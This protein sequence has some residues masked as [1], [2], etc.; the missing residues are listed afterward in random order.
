MTKAISLA[1][2]LSQDTLLDLSEGRIDVIWHHKFY[3]SESCQT[4]MPKIVEAC[5]AAN[6][7]LTGDLQSLGTSIGEAS[8]SEVAQSRYLDT[9][10][11]TTTQIR[12]DIFGRLA[13]PA[14]LV[15]LRCD[16]WWP[17]G[18]TLARYE[19]RQMLASIVRRWVKGG[20]ANP[21]IDQKSV[22]L[23]DEYRLERRI[24]VNVYLE[25]PPADGGGE[26]DFW[27]SFTDESQYM[28]IKRQD[29]G[30][31]R[32]NLGEP[33][34]SIHPEQ[35]DLVMFDAARVHG[36]RRLTSGSRITA[37][38]FLGVRSTRDPIVVF[39]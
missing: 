19:G 37:A 16:E 36:V 26:V 9:A 38:C 17:A 2:E 32:E 23:L 4:A 28:S 14:D 7:T 10:Q 24:G 39:A 20:H 13:A 18:V 6:Y 1:H 3:P 35:G 34:L 30:I 27:H 8:E 11:H 12:D 29:Y 31:D 22:P 15:R 5:E 33:L 21:H 25:T